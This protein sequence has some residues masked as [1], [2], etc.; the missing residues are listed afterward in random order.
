MDAYAVGFGIAVL[1]AFGIGSM[2]CVDKCAER[3]FSILKG[4]KTE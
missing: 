1:V 3:V 2:V 4:T